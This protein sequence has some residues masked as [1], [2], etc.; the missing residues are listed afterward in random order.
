VRAI[1]ADADVRGQVR[2]LASILNGPTWRE[3]WAQLQLSLLTFRALGLN[4]NVSDA[5][6]WQVCQQQQ[7]VLITANRNA[8]GPDSLEATLRAHNTLTSLPVFTL[9]DPR[10][11]LHSREYA[12]RVVESLLEHLLE[13]DAY[14][15]AGRLYLP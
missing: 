1:L 14:R 15:G 6:L 4:P 5:V 12:E 9:A 10:R 13:I 8:E 11:V 2:V 7:V 3:L